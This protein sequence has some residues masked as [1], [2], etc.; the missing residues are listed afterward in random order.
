MRPQ[1]A[2]ERTIAIITTTLGLLITGSLILIGIF[3]LYILGRSLYNVATT[4]D[5][6][7]EAKLISVVVL[8]IVGIAVLVL[9]IFFALAISRRFERQANREGKLDSSEHKAVSQRIVESE[10]KRIPPP[11]P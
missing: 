2:F 8:G 3:V 6:D 5:F 4:G 1:Q 11:R 7:N 10:A 9:L